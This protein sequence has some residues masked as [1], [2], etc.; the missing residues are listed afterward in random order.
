MFQDIY[1]LS[2]RAGAAKDAKFKIARYELLTFGSTRVAEKVQKVRGE[3]TVLN[4]RSVKYIFIGFPTYFQG[5]IHMYLTL[6]TP[7]SPK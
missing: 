2:Y 7:L 4:I 3:A 5:L 1:F 6:S